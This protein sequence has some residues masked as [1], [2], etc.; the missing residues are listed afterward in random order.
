MI[1]RNPLYRPA[2]AEVYPSAEAALA[3]CE[4]AE[5]VF[6]IGGGEIYRNFMP[7]ANALELTEID[8]SPA[9]AD[10]FF[11]GAAGFEIVEAS[12]WEG[13]SPRYRFVKLARPAA[14]Q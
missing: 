10:T 8:A 2:G 13:E 9:D 14:G 1:S 11:P 5:R 12:E 6:I 3:A 4:G 7:L